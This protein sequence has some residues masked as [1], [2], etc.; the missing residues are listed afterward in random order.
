MWGAS[1]EWTGAAALGQDRGLAGLCK[2]F[3]CCSRKLKANVEWHD[4]T[5]FLVSSW[6]LKRSYFLKL[7]KQDCAKHPLCLR[8]TSQNRTPWKTARTHMNAH[9][10]TCPET[11]TCFSCVRFSLST[12]LRRKH[13]PH[14]PWAPWITWGVL[15]RGGKPAWHWEQIHWD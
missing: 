12:F 6:V 1:A 7:T 13:Y 8:P 11:Q 14:A 5:F 4:L 3:G 10:F 2:D 15:N 9:L